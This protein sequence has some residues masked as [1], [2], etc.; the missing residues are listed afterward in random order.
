MII[1]RLSECREFISGDKAVL[2]E[3]LNA[4]K[5]GFKFRYS[6]AHAILKPGKNTKP[7]R[8]KTSEVYYILEGKGIMHIDSENSKVNSGCAIYIPPKAVQYLENCGKSDLIF[9]CI[10]DPAWRREDEEIIEE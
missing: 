1:K 4:R 10:V 3:L 9:L 2:R 7:H 8:L 6:L 5:D